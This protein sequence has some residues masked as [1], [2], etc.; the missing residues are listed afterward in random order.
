MT[1]SVVYPDL[2]P[3]LENSRISSLLLPSQMLHNEFASSG[4][5]LP[6]CRDRL[7]E[8][9]IYFSRLPSGCS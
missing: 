4:S 5:S 3:S 9:G 1:S 7:G 6:L 8:T 2:A